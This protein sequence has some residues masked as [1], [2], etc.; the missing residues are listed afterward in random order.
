M[1]RFKSIV[2]VL[3]ALSMSGSLLVGCGSSQTTQTAGS[4]K[5][6]ELKFPSFWVGKDSKAKVIGDLITKFN[7]ANK[8]KI[9]VTVEEIADYNA[10]EDK[11][12]T[13]IATNSV[14]DL[15]IFKSGT[16]ADVYYK[17]GKL[18]DFT[19]YMNAGWKD[20]FIGT[21]IKDSTYNNQVLSIPYEYGVAPVIYNQALLTKAGITSFP[22]TYTEFFDMCDK[23][24]AKGIIPMSQMT[25]D[26]A[27]TSMLW[28]SQLV[29]SIGGPDVYSRGLSDPAFLEAAKEIQKMYKYTTKDAIGA[30]AAV[31]SGHFLNGE[32]AMIMNGPWYIGTIKSQGKN[33][34]Y[35]NVSVAPAPM[36]EGG[37]GKDN[38]YIGFV[39]SNLG[40]AKQ[41]DKGKEA[42][43]IKFLKYLTDPTNIKTISTDSGSMFVIKT[44]ADASDKVEKLQGMMTTQTNSAPYVVPHFQVMEKAAVGNE[45]PQAL[46]GLVSGNKTPQQFID[47]LKAKD[48]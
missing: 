32:T 8:G 9:K 27:W 4:Q 37:L 22:K 11:M 19:S 43:V 23:L 26:N 41:T 10:Y 12:K 28:Y 2:T 42:A 35:D 18:M 33:N 3:L 7:E 20:A 36:Y 31:A 24:E 5:E 15:F 21:S 6:Y 25:G 14:P 39:Q 47:Q 46:A 16:I 30:T 48:K 44:T 29:V 1:K 45:F 40:A 13:S 38:G 34:L 17:S